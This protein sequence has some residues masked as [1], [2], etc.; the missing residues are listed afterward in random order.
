VVGLTVPEIVQ[1]DAVAVKAGTVWLAP[2]IV[3]FWEVGVKVKPGLLGV[4]L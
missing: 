3:T 2:L 4:M 1:V